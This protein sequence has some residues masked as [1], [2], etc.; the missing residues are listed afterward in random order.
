MVI[1][2]LYERTLKESMIDKRTN[3]KLVEELKKKDL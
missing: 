1:T 2:L 3:E